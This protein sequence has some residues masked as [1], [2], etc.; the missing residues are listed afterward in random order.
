MLLY[1]TTTEHQIALVEDC[2]LSGSYRAL[3]L[4]EVDLDVRRRRAR[5][6]PRQPDAGGGF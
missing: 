4:V 6:S 5:S 3:R 1:P 2:G